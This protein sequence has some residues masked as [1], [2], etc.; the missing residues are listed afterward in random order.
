MTTLAQALALALSAG[1]THPAVVPHSV[2]ERL[3]R[4]AYDVGAP[5][6]LVAAVCAVESGAD[7]RR[8][9][10]WCGAIVHGGGI[11]AQPRAAARSLVHG[12][13]RCGGRTTAA[14]W[15]RAAGYYHTGRC[16]VDSY[17]RTVL[18]LALAVGGAS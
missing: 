7:P 15:A 13:A 12:L 3:A 1:W 11:E 4:A 17:A 9:V 8:T 10:A 2:G 16:Q 18:R 6:Q 14:R 5:P